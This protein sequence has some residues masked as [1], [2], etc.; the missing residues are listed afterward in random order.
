M[1]R[2]IATSLVF[3]SLSSTAAI[4][5]PLK[6]DY[7][8]QGTATF[9]PRGS[10][11]YS[12]SY[13]LHQ[14]NDPYQVNGLNWD[15]WLNP[16]PPEYLR[17]VSANFAGV[18]SSTF[19]TSDGWSY[20]SAA[21]ELSDDSL[22]V[23]I[24]AARSGDGKVGAE[25]LVEYVP[26]GNDPVDVHWIQGVQSNH[27]VA[28]GTPQNEV[29]YRYAGAP[30]YDQGGTATSRYLY[31]FPKREWDQAHT[32]KGE[33]YLVT[34]TPIVNQADGTVRPTPG[35]VTFLGGIRWGW[36]NACVGGGGAGGGAG[37]GPDGDHDDMVC[38]AQTPEPGT[39]VLIA[40]GLAGF[41]RFRQRRGLNRQ[42]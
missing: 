14:H 29:D 33:L 27:G 31:D 32:W 23:R 2:T 3:I 9:T 21:N 1:I 39:L 20:Q 4:A 16:D 8:T 41:A 40:S 34:G 38:A 36:E 10:V 25:L 17:G 37:G 13:G 7:A 18:M 26:H 24:Y 11:E 12:Y 28:H 22:V 30:Y 5:T 35:A 42:A 6:L 19:K 15:V